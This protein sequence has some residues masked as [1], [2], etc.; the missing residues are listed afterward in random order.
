[1]KKAE[2]MNILNMTIFSQK[3]VKQ[4]YMKACSKY[5]P[6]RNP[7]GL[8]MMKAVNVAYSFLKG[9]PDLDETLATE[10]TGIDF[11][12][13]MNAAIN[14]VIDLEGVFM[15]ICGNWIWLS[16]DTRTYKEAIKAAGYFWASKKM[17]W[18]FRPAE[19]KSKGRG[20]FTM[21]EIRDAHG[22]DTVRS[23]A[24]SKTKISKSFQP[25]PC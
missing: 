10:G 13:L 5:H 8:E 6:D 2:A 20:Q 21:A 16:G 25:A 23:A 22:S 3:I 7:G 15:E 18:Y 19:W 11:G 12:D 17:M 9:L 4:A 24:K 14:A 1:M